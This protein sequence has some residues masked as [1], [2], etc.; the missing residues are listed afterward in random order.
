MRTALMLLMLS[1]SAWAQRGTPPPP[2]PRPAT[3]VA[4][5]G[6][7]TPEKMERPSD[8]PDDEK[9]KRSA[10]TLARV[11]QIFKDVVSMVEQA[12]RTKDVIKL[13]CVNEKLSQMRGLL[14]IT[15]QADA[16]LTEAIARKEQSAVDHEYTKTSIARTRAEQMRAEAEACVGQLVFS[17]DEGQ[18]VEVEEPP[19]LPGS[20]PTRP[21]I[22]PPVVSRPPPSSPVL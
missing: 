12:R 14:R 11:K 17:T 15:E 18:I 10:A 8:V 5:S 9:V 1:G 19:D 13:N 16:G 3:V 6:L 2:A 4:P 21:G 22:P 7:L 20:D